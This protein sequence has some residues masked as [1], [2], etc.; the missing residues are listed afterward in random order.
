MSENNQYEDWIRQCRTTY[1]RERPRLQKEHPDEWVAIDGI[2]GQGSK[3]A[4]KKFQSDMNLPVTGTA[5]SQ[6]KQALI[7][8]ANRTKE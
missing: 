4:I 2:L 6:T 7:D 1:E 5:D 3:N 8:E